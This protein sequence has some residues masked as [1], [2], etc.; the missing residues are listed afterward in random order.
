MT[1][2]QLGPVVGYTIMRTGQGASFEACIVCP[3]VDTPSSLAFDESARRLDVQCGAVAIS[4]PDIPGDIA[5]LL[6]GDPARV[7]LIT[8]DTLSTVRSSAR[9]DVLSPRKDH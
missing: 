6:T 9:A 1:T 2:T 8:A 3:H 4:L 7:L 5:K